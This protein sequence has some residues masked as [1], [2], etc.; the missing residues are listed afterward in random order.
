MS[1]KHFIQLADALKKE[2]ESRE[3]EN[4]RSIIREVI[5]AVAGVC[6]RNNNLF[7]YGRFLTACGVEENTEKKYFCCKGIM[8]TGNCHNENCI[9]E[10]N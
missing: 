8:E 1:K 4:E 2:Y 5:Y 3:N 7:D 6:S 10:K 9:M